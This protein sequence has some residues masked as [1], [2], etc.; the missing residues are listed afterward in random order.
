M[1]PKDK[2]DELVDKYKD[3]VLY[4]FTT[5]DKPFFDYQKQC[6]LIAV[7]EILNLNDI[8]GEYSYYLA[9]KTEIEKL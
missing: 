5:D 2:C 6:A 9:V 7:D 3:F 1:T 8:D 4:D